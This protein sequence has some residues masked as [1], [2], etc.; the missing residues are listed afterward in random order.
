MNDQWSMSLASLIVFFIGHA[1]LK[2][3]TE[4]SA[5]KTAYNMKTRMPGRQ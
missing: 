5:F 1:L 3:L 4:W 2:H